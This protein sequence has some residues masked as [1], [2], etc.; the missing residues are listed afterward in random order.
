MNLKTKI[1]CF[2]VLLITVSGW[3]MPVEA[4]AGSMSG[5]DAQALDAYISGQ[6][7]KHGI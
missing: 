4:E 6:M 2:L 3:T 7:S 1:A 5:F